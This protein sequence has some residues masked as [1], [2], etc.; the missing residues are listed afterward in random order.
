VTLL[1]A[2]AEKVVVTPSRVK[3]DKGMKNTYV[4]LFLTFSEAFQAETDEFAVFI[5]HLRRKGR[6]RPTLKIAAIIAQE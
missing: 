2:C 4:K 3:E 5:Q 6:V 1:I